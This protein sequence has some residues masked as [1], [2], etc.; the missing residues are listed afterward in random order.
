MSATTYSAE[1]YPPLSARAVA[2]VANARTKH[3]DF[4]RKQKNLVFWLHLFG[5]VMV[6]AMVVDIGI[7][8][9]FNVALISNQRDALTLWDHF[10]RGIAAFAM[11]GTLMA[12]VAG[13]HTTFN[14]RLETGKRFL[15]FAVTLVIAAAVFMVASAIGYSQLSSILG[16]L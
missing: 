1:N 3:A 8:I 13:V 16:Q 6:L 15:A 14:S 2:V 12:V 7:G 4:F 5:W 11:V 10:V 9:T